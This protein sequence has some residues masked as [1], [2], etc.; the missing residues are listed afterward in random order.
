MLGSRHGG[1]GYSPGSRVIG[2]KGSGVGPADRAW[3]GEV[4]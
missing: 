3:G 2:V 4:Q 1:H